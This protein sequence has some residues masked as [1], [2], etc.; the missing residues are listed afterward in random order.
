MFRP[1]IQ[2][3][4]FDAAGTLIHLAEPVGA[5]YHRIALPFEIESDPEAIERAFRAVWKRTPPPFSASR[6]LPHSDEKTWWHQLVRKVFE[7]SGARGIEGD[8]FDPFFEKLYDHF[9]APGT[10]TAYPGTRE[11]LARVS[12]KIPCVVL[13]NFDHRLRRILDD[14]ELAKY[15]EAIILSSEVKASKPSPRMFDRVAEHFGC[16]RE[17]ILHVGDDPDCDGEGASQ[18]GMKFFRVHR[19]GESLSRLLRQLSLA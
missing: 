8:R 10:W 6:F 18:A 4:S 11:V 17:A 19:G 9:E 13:S 5:S 14:L 15:F 3:C 2:G 7:E 12:S 1:S 16:P